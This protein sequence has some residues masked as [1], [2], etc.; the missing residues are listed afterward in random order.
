MVKKLLFIALIAGV[1]FFAVR[2]L[3][4]A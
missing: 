1:G 4:A 3:K 2:K